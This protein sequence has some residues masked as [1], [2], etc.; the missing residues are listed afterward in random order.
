MNRFTEDL[1]AMPMNETRWGD[2]PALHKIDQIIR[3]SKL[4]NE[5]LDKFKS[6]MFGEW[7][8]LKR[9]FVC[10]LAAMSDED[11]MECFGV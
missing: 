1:L 3:N 10:L 4:T 5:F 7:V 11:L 2:S 8:E 6:I 9:T